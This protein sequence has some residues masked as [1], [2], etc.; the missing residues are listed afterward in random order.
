MK[1]GLW[2]VRKQEKMVVKKEDVMWFKKVLRSE[3]IGLCE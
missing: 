3:A 2:D 1:A